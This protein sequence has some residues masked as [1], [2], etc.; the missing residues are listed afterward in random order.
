MSDWNTNIDGADE[1]TLP[2][3]APELLDEVVHETI[4]EILTTRVS[5]NSGGIAV[6][7]ATP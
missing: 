5:V 7:T 4:V 3:L 1:L 6:C 2:V